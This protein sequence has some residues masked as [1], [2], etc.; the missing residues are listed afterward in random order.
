L[1]TALSFLNCIKYPPSLDYLL[2]T[3]GP[4]IILL[5]LI[6]H[7]RLSS[8]HPLLV[9]GRVPMFYYVLHLP[10]IHAVAVVLAGI[11]YGDPLF[12]FKH[13]LPVLG[14]A[15]SAFP[16]H[17]GY[18]LLTTYV[19]W[20]LIVSSLY[21]PCRWYASLKASRHEAWLSYL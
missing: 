4:A 9:F 6:E 15:R 7:V 20:I 14:G 3:L 11:R 2:M 18:N 17:Y 12:L 1:F 10:L 8:G 21:L 13:T 19:I 16:P 5:S